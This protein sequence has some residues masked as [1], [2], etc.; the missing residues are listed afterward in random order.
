MNNPYE[1]LPFDL[2]IDIE[3]EV[4]RKLS[5]FYN[6]NPNISEKLTNEEKET[7]KEW[8]YTTTSFEF[9]RLYGITENELKEYFRENNIN[10]NNKLPQFKDIKIRK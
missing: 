6:N 1:K 10:A 9:Y 8:I 2:Y 7:I 3:N 4:E 5:E